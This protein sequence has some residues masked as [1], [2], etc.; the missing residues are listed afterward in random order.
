MH[1]NISQQFKVRDAHIW[2]CPWT[3]QLVRKLSAQ[4]FKMVVPLSFIF[5]RPNSRIQIVKISSE[6]C[7]FESQN[8]FLDR[9]NSNPKL[10]YNPKINQKSSNFLA[11]NV[12]YIILA[13]KKITHPFHRWSRTIRSALVSDCD[14]HLS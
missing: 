2:T 1:H 8:F 13:Y 9:A 12:W 7:G 11:I 10:C 5:Q 3:V 14:G 4:S 6:L